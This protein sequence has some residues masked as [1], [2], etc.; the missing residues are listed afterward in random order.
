[1]AHDPTGTE[2]GTSPL[3]RIL[4]ADDHAVLRSGLR[5]L[6]DAEPDMQVVGEARDGASALAQVTALKPDVLLL[7]ITM[8][9]VSGLETLGQIHTIAPATRVIVLTMHDDEGYLR[10]ALAAGAAGY[11][12]KRAADVELL[13]AVRAVHGGGTYLHPAHTRALLAAQTQRRTTDAIE[14]E[15]SLSARER[16][17]LHLVALGYT[18]RQA[19]SELHL[20]PKTVDTYRARIMAKLGLQNRAELV[21]YAMSRG[22]LQEE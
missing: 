15:P 1:V 11:V 19:A 22:L 17:V 14:A 20:S 6:L 2:S 18:S 21:R 7:D 3:I 4:I 9:E 16:E 13:S 10:E 5:M 12:L 8:P